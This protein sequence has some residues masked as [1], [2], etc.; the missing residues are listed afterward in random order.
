MKKRIERL[1]EDKKSIIEE[2]EKMIKIVERIL[3]FNQLEQLKN[4]NTKLNAW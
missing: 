3:Y 1:S 4:T 2:N